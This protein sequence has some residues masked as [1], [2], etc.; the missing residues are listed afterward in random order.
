VLLTSGDL[1]R[2]N[3][4]ARLFWPNAPAFEQLPL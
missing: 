4:I 2:V 1:A 3:R